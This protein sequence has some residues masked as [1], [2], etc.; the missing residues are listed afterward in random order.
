MQVQP[1]RQFRQNNNKTLSYLVLLI[2]IIIFLSTVGVRLLINTSVFINNLV[3]GG[4]ITDTRHTDKLRANPEIIDVPDA[5]HSAQIAV[6]IGNV[7][8][9]NVKVIVNDIIQSEIFYDNDS[10]EVNIDLNEGV[11][12]LSVEVEGSETK[13]VKRSPVYRVTYIEN[14]PELEVSS[15]VDGSITD[16][17]EI[18]I[19]GKVKEDI[20]VR[21]NG[22]PVVVSGDG[23]FLT[24]VRLVN[25]ENKITVEATNLAGTTE[26]QTITVRYE[27]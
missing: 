15:P 12:T 2:V 9:A 11:N 10:V 23:S 5:T 20:S 24:S 19:T 6:T 8:D 7:K 14:K 27:P 4:K 1:R 26:T 18:A 16:K 22:Q 13:E 25:G 3:T 21:V 17:Q